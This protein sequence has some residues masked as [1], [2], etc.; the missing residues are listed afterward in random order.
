MKSKKLIVVI[1]MHRS[2]TSA[3]TR[4]LELLGV[5]LG[6]NLHPAAS[7]NPKGFWEDSECLEINEELLSYFGSAYDQL[8]GGW[9]TS[10]ANSEVSRIKLKASQLISKKLEENTIWGFKD[11]RTSRLLPF[12][13]DVFSSLGCDVGYVIALRNPVSI[14]DS[15]SKR[16]KT[17]AE[18]TYFLWL[19]HMLP[20]LQMTEGSRRVVVDYDEFMDSPYDQIKRVGQYLDLHIAEPESQEVQAFAR[21][22]LDKGLRH[23]RYTEA[24]LRLDSRAPLIVC[25]AYLLMLRLSRD[26]LELGTP[27]TNDI[28]SRLRDDLAEFLPIINLVNSLEGERSNLWSDVARLESVS[29]E[30]NQLLIKLHAEAHKKNQD[31]EAQKIQLQQLT[32]QVEHQTIQAQNLERELD[33]ILNSSSWKVTKPLRFLRRVLF[34][35]VLSLLVNTLGSAAR[36]T[37]HKLPVSF[38]IKSK[39]KTTLFTKLPFLFSWSQAYRSWFGMNFSGANLPNVVTAFNSNEEDSSGCYVQLLRSSPPKKLSVRLIAFYLPQFHAIKENNEWWG[40]GFT[41][42]TNVK[43]ARPQ[44]DGHYQPHVPGELGY[45]NLLDRDVQKRQIELA[46]LYGVGGFCFYYYWFGGKRLLEQPIENYLADSSLDH[47]FCLCWANENWSRRWDGKDSEVLIAQQHSPEDDL[48][49]AADVA[50]YIRDERYICIDGKPLLI[51]YRPS[52][53]PSALETSDRWRT[54]FRDQG[55]GEIYLAYTQSF[56]AE[57]PRKY[58]FDAAIEFP[59]NNSA[60]PNITSQMKTAASFGGTVYDWSV[61]LKRSQNY[62]KNAYRLFRSVCPSWDN[63]ARRKNGG[64]VFLNST[65]KD[66]QSWLENAIAETCDQAATTDERLVFVNAW[67]EWAEGAHLEPDAKYG[68]AWLDAT[69]KALTGENTRDQKVKIAVVSHD[70]HPHGAQFLALGMVRSLVNDLKLQ[71]HTVLLGEGRLRGEFAQY[72]PVY[73][74]LP[75]TD[76]ESRSSHLARQLSANGVQQA[77]VNTTVSGVFVKAL[78]AEGIRCVSLIHEMP[79]VIEANNLVPQVTDIANFAHRLVFPASI[80]EEGFVK[81]VPV[82]EGKKLI[83]PQGLWRRNLL[84]FNK[85]QVRNEVR[86]RLGINA[87]AP[88]VLAVGYADRRK[89]IDLFV[90]AALEILGSKPDTLFVWIGHWDETLRQEIDSLIKEHLVSF[91]FLG[92]EPET[93]SYHAAADVYALTSREDPFPNVVLE[94]F[95]AGVPVVAFEGT[96]GGAKLVSGV[97]GRVVPAGDVQA[98]AQAVIS[99]IQQPDVARKLGEQAS[100]LVDRDYAFRSY[101]FDLCEYVGIELPKISV[102]VPNYNY[103]Q[104]ICQRLDSILR[105]SLPIYELIILDDASKDDSVFKIKQWMIDNKVE[106]RLVVNDHN[107]GSV[108]DQW[109]KGVQLATGDFVWIAEADDLS[110]SD[111][112]QSVIAP[113]ERDME[114]TVS[115]CESQ[116]IDGASLRLSVDYQ[117][118]RDDICSSHWQIPYIADG[119]DE[120]VNFLAI[121]NTIPNVSGVLFRREALA[122]T[123]E[124]HI[125]RIRSLTKAGDWLTYVITLKGAKIAFDPRPLNFHRRHSG[126][127]IG[128]SNAVRLLDEIVTVQKSIAAEYALPGNVSQ[129]AAAYVDELK[130]QF[131]LGSRVSI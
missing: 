21:E 31:F 130:S 20:S 111:F 131:G 55:I 103:A 41:E 37:W 52:L 32:F 34:G 115:Y 95:D 118:Y 19:Q 29:S 72:A 39:I 74:L 65:P 90:K 126:S 1:G 83:R 107:S 77:I 97:G 49:F 101:L 8:G 2:G 44:F 117:A 87:D 15:L 71:V 57:D 84:R 47:P 26:E 59:P 67:N 102:V 91:K 43:P 46:K 61:F 69:R 11:P 5:G 81:F 54:W 112:L 70:A 23:S 64:T 33:Q 51:V 50:R 9:D 7:D 125:D 3:I 58:G 17:P 22:F 13:K 106:C 25:D 48:A 113:M 36:N 114:V 88:I 24:Q 108:F 76:F 66:Y 93:A 18:K 56:E 40:E 62:K 6:T 86:I 60:P 116:Q 30:S 78:A 94:S 68:Y 89:G 119:H 80:V 100:A 12:W 109:A 14:V 27:V 127:V 38:E 128:G 110:S 42:W 10:I 85:E 120:V 124:H 104:Y 96:G 99:L 123:F 63:T 121:K 92:Y 122:N 4:G 16:N 79:G 105:Q 28:L 75:G 98:F 129:Q 53:L 73:D 82:D 35:R 45:Y